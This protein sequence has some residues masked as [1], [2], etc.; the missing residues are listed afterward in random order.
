MANDFD[1]NTT[2]KLVR[3]FLKAFEASRVLCKGIDTQLLDGRF[4][5]TSGT[6]VDVKRPHDY[7][8]ARTSAGDISSSGKSDIT[9]G[10]ATATVQN[11]FTVGADFNSV[12]EALKLDQLDEIIAPMATRMVTDL[13]LDLAS[14]MMK[15]C[16]LSYGTPGTAIDAWTDVAGAG[17]LMDSMGVPKDKPWMYVMNPYT[18]QALANVQHGLSPGSSNKV[19]SAWERAV[20][21]ENLGGM[22]VMTSNALASRT[23]TTAADLIGSLSGT[24][25]LTYVGAKDTMTQVWAVTGF[26]ASAVVKAGDIIEV[27]GRYRASGATREAIFS[28]GAQV[29]FRATVTADVTLGASGEGNLVMAGAGIWETGGSYNTTTDALASSDVITILG[30]S[31]TAVQP[32]LFFHPQAFGLATVKLPKLYSTDTIATTEDGFSIRCSKYADGDANSQTVRF[33]LLPAYATFNPMAAGQGFG[34]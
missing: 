25:T 17:A 28:G 4:N 14:Y 27:T 1:S 10:K 16:N 18:A 22:R 7:T 8:T 34:V 21:S 11:Y 29:L 33:D 24:P 3:S 26:T 19:D 31:A 2:R 15:N 12:D 6:T 32:A 9:S 30:A 13:E 23:V 20:V 5:P